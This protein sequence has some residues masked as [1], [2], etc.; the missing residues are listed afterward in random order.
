MKKGKEMRKIFFMLR[1][2]YCGSNAYDVLE[3]EDD[4]TE[5]QLNEVAWDM[6]VQNAESYGYYLCSDDCY[7]DEC[8]E[9]HPGSTN[10]EGSWEEYDPAEHDM[11]L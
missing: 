11:Y 8:E 10:I 9:E 2:G 5:D 1:T 4:V 7:D 3:F 6:A